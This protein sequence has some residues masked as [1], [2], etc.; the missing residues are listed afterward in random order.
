V[1]NGTGTSAISTPGFD[2]ATSNALRSLGI[3]ECT[4]GEKD[5]ESCVD[6]A[7]HSLDLLL[8]HGSRFIGATGREKN[9]WFLDKLGV[10]NVR[11]LVRIPSSTD[12]I[13]TFRELSNLYPDFSYAF[14]SGA[15]LLRFIN[16]DR[17][18]VCY[19]SHYANETSNRAEGSRTDGP[20]PQMKLAT[21][22]HPSSLTYL[23]ERL[24]EE[25]WKP[26]VTQ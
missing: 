6:E 24:F 7:T 2:L 15:P 22:G 9:K 19:L 16:I 3:S 5:A 4:A 8:H 14:Y 20:A 18:A 21:V 10:L 23:A 12:E 13:R 25:L 26:G 17:G 1:T 11:M